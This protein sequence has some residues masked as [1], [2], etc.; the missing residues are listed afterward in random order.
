MK[1]RSGKYY[2]DSD[3]MSTENVTKNTTN[4]PQN[5]VTNLPNRPKY[6]GYL[7]KKVGHRR[8]VITYSS[9]AGLDRD[10]HHGIFT[11]YLKLLG[12]PL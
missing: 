5:N 3:K 9:L 7:E 1:V 4:T 8:L 6:L 12:N 11:L 2:V 10:F